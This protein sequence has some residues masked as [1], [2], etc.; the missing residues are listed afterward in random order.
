MNLRP[1]T[2][3]QA[4]YAPVLLFTLRA[5]WLFIALML[6]GLLGT[7]ALAW[8]VPLLP[9]S[10]TLL[11]LAAANSVL[12]TWHR[13][14]GPEHLVELGLIADILTL[15]ELLYLTGGIANPMASLYLPP[16][17]LAA[18]VCSVHF[19]WGMAFVCV[20]TYFLLFQFHL[21]FP[22]P[23][24]EPDWLFRI[25]IGGM[26]LTFALSAA[27]IT[28]C[29]TWLIQALNWRENQL[30]RAHAQQQQNEQVLSLGIEAAHTAHKLSTPLNSLLLL[31]DEL[32]ARTDLP[33]EV[34]QDL[35]LMRSQLN[36]CRDVLWQLKPKDQPQARPQP[37]WLYATLNAQ[38]RHWHNLRPEAHYTWQ[39][40]SPIAP[41]VCVQLDPLFWSAFLNILNNAADAGKQSVAL[42]TRITAAQTLIIGIRNRSG[43]LSEA[44]LRHAGL[45]AQ[46]S[47]K[48][49]GLGMGVLL[50]HA[51][52]AR[53]HGSLTLQNHHDG[54][55]Y[56]EIRLPLTPCPAPKTP[57]KAA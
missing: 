20:T 15:S 1:H 29:I 32:Q 13:R 25:H 57:T 30:Q 40:H 24:Q 26:W 8:P 43:F 21:P 17:L 42:E 28:A 7:W 46:Q 44:Q 37:T 19:A 55:V 54:G 2:F 9:L 14:H 16:L 11:F 41:D 35:A 33:A 27:L 53:M 49:A 12:S 39:Q 23:S 10:L 22:V 45:N 47:D 56:A 6:A 36:Q 38:L 18:L 5:R 48:P 4:A 51:T 31:T 3:S 34:S 52:L 50:S